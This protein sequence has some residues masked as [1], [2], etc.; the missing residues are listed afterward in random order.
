MLD[1]ALMDPWEESIV[2]TKARTPSKR[3]PKAPTSNGVGQ[4]G[5]PPPIPEA[6]VEELAKLSDEELIA[7]ANHQHHQ[8]RGCMRKAIVEHARLAGAALLAM[9]ARLT[10]ARKDGRK[11]RDWGAWL[12]ANFAG[13]PETARLYM[14]IAESWGRIVAHGLDKI[15]DLALE[16]LRWFL[17][18]PK[19]KPSEEDEPGATADAGQGGPTSTSHVPGAN[20]DGAAED[21]K[22]DAAAAGQGQGGPSVVDV[23]DDGRRVIDLGPALGHLVVALEDAEQFGSAVERLTE[24]G[25]SEKPARVAFDAVVAEHLGMGASPHAEARRL[26]AS[27]KA[28]GVPAFVTHGLRQTAAGVGVQVLDTHTPQQVVENIRKAVEPQGGAGTP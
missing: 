6:H 16:D 20:G 3:R 22:A 9:K 12:Q 23:A 25:G 24:S 21:R 27:V 26:L 7:F 19:P 1:P 15:P 8:F 5:S 18:D 11:R 14:R 17:S 10:Q 4:N 28:G 2:S 13:S